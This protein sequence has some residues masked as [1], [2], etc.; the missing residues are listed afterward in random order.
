MSLKVIE[1]K[2]YTK[3]KIPKNAQDIIPLKSIT[4]EGI[5]YL[6]TGR[7]SMTYEMQDID[8]FNLDE[9]DQK[10]IF[11]KYGDILNSLGGT[12][13]SYKFTI[14]KRN[15]DKKAI[16]ARKMLSTNV[17]DSFDYL[18][19][20]YNELRKNDIEKDQMEICKYITVSTVKKDPTKAK[21]F[22]NRITA[23]LGRRFGKLHS[24]VTPLDADDR[25]RMFF[26]FFNTG[27]ENM[28]VPYMQIK[29]SKADIRTAICPDGP[30]FHND[31]FE[32]NS[33]MGRVMILRIWSK[34]IKD[35]FL[36]ELTGLDTNFMLSLDIIP[37][38]AAEIDKALEDKDSD[39]ESSIINWS[40]TKN[41]KNNR[42]AQVPR[43][44]KKNRKIL[45]EYT[46][47]IYERD[48]K[49]FLCQLTFAFLADDKE[50]LEEYTESVYE[51]ASE[52]TCN[53]GTMWFQQ[54]EGLINT[55][56]FGIRTIQ[57]LRDCNTETTAMLIPFNAQKI[58]HDTGIPYGRQL[59]TGEQVFIDRRVMKNGN[60]IV[61]GDSGSG[62]SMNTKLKALFEALTTNGN[63]IFIDPD[64]EYSKLVKALGGTVIKIGVD[65]LN[66]F[67]MLDGYGY[68]EVD[69]VKAKSDFIISLIERIID[70][71]EAYDEAKKSLTDRCVIKVCDS[72]KYYEKGSLTLVDF[73]N[74]LKVQPEPEALKLA[75][76][77]E[78]HI[79]GSFNVFAKPTT[80][81]IN[82]RIQCFDLS[83]LDKQLKNAGMMVCL[84]Y[85]NNILAMNRHYGKAT[86]IR[87]DELDEYLKHPAS[88]KQ[89]ETFFQR[90]RK[91][92][93]FCT[94]LI[95]NIDKLL[96]IPE[97]RTM[98]KNSQNVIMM[99]QAEEDARILAGLYDLSDQDMDF[100]MTCEPGYGINRIGSNNIFRFDG[101]IP[102]T[103]A[104]YQFINTDGHSVAV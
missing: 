59:S 11:F 41:A 34:N 25:L 93:G 86:Y 14:Y 9:E 91:Y 104:I 67:D 76:D 63:L 37:L 52:Y 13:A 28:Y 73:Y 71:P 94:G 30:T 40:N 47:D 48:Q 61:L 19:E 65:N 18:R 96:D 26:D 8:Y 33:K 38:S 35:D 79:T 102:T 6:G 17:N 99:G 64:G 89:V 27:H 66:A 50:T 100:L 85:V 103:N 29:D 43:R 16:A 49:V 21:G 68:G 2:D 53:I 90:A 97:A 42:A 92:G 84:D 82:N 88:R 4:D 75:L 54:Y 39:V 78:R 51:T 57:S 81:S 32:L 69:P 74:E 60:E 20:A 44:M 31:Y 22:Y 3:I 95:Q 45:D 7:Y 70:N 101:T 87:L 98:L 72:M 5:A 12:N 80:V 58:Q 36:A 46:E 56:P 1:K 83:L 55:V 15:R 24:G 62:K 10:S 77:I 23:D